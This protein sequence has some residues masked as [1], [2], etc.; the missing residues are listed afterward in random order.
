[1]QETARGS[2]ASERE[3]AVPENTAIMEGVLWAEK[4]WYPFHFSGDG[5]CSIYV[6]K[7]S[8]CDMSHPGQRSQDLPTSTW[9]TGGGAPASAALVL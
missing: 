4:G 5:M 6:G 7:L 3:A 1:M 8:L 2:S 9:S